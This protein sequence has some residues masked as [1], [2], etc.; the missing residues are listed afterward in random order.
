M[1]SYW[2]TGYEIHLITAVC[3][4]GVL[5]FLTFMVWAIEDDPE[6]DSLQKTNHWTLYLLGT[7][8]V[9]LLGAYIAAIIVILIIIIL[10]SLI[11][12]GIKYVTMKTD[13]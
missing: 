3:G 5:A 11:I 2:L 12:L 1:I 9:G 7:I 6:L 8:L 4:G 13:N 10:L